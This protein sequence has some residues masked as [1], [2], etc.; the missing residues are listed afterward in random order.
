MAGFRD[1]LTGLV[2][3][4]EAR[5]RQLAPAVRLARSNSGAMRAY[6][7]YRNAVAESI[8]ELEADAYAS[9]VVAALIFWVIS[10]LPGEVTWQ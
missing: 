6:L 5:A 4:V 10:I 1:R 7:R 9:L 2:G 3:R 8:G